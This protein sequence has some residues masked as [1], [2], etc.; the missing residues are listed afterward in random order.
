MTDLFFPVKRGAW[1]RAL[2]GV[3]LGGMLAAM[4]TARAQPA[5]GIDQLMQALARNKSGHAAFVEKK[6]IG[7]LDRPVESSGELIY[8][9]P[10]RLEKRT[11]KP[12]PESMVLVGNTLTL[13]RGPRRYVLALQDY[14]ELGAFTESIRGTLAGDEKALARVYDIALDGTEQHWT[15]TL[16]PLQPKMAAAVQSIVLQGHAAEVRS[17]EIEQTDHDHSVMTITPVPSP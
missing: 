3:L 13:E 6:Y 14:P 7:M 11:L 5:W 8:S 9:A 1:P 16:R 12:K 2:A 4:C 17:I 10:D 15:L